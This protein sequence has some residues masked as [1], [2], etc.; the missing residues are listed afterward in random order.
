MAKKI[1]NGVLSLLCLLALLLSLA[2]IRALL[3]ARPDRPPTLFGHSLMVVVSGSM[4]PTFPVGTLILSRQATP[5]QVE[6]GDIITFYGTVGSTTGVITHRVAAK[7]GTGDDAVLT[8]KGDANPVQDPNPVMKEGLIGIV[9]WQSPFW[10]R[11]VGTLRKKQV[12]I[13]LLLIPLALLL[14]E[15]FLRRASARQ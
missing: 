8:T 15:R 6:V 3:T 10:G 14:G 9:I 1:F 2:A 12:F 11:V 13:P 4:E 7:M 5:S